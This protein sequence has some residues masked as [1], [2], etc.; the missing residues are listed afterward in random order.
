MPGQQK[1]G[2]PIGYRVLP[3]HYNMN[4]QLTSD[5]F[6]NALIE[7]NRLLLVQFKKEWNGP[8]QIIAPLYTELSNNYSHLADFIT[9][10]QELAPGVEQLFG[11]REL[12]TILFFYKGQIID[13][14]IGLTPKNI[15]IEK[16]EH[17]LATG[18]HDC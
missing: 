3:K 17:A 7:S 9:I 16:I 11:V 10:D 15:L 5:E 2:I 6:K 13:H 18:T 12:P 8:S 14:A 1:N 4:R